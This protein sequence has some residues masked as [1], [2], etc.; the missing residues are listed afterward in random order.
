MFDF[1]DLD[2][3]RS[4]FI[5]KDAEQ[6]YLT[7]YELLQLIPDLQSRMENTNMKVS[8]ITKDSSTHPELFVECLM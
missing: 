1:L 8:M 7:K 2:D 3:G 5:I 4:F 6:L